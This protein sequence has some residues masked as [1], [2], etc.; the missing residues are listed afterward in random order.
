M[1]SFANGLR[2]LD[3]F[4]EGRISVHVDDVVKM[5]ASSKATAYRYLGFLCDAGLLSPT[6][7]GTYV[8]GPRII[9]LDRL[10]RIS[11]PLLTLH[12]TGD[13]FVPI[14][15]EQSYLAK[16]KAAGK[17][18]LLVQRAIRAAGHCVFTEAEQRAAW[19]DLVAWVRDSK[20]PANC[21]SPAATSSSPSRSTSL[22]A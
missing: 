20:K 1:S 12:N 10:M 8:L 15:M 5:L 7:G 21:S 13:L 22:T 18:D 4:M 2:I 11:D 17:G 3:L 14:S 19:N 9:E 6:S 16:V